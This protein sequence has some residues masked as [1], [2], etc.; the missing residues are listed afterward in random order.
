MFIVKKTVYVGKLEFIREYHE[1][2]AET[3]KIVEQ[4]FQKEKQA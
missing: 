3:E 4:L 2:N 1:V